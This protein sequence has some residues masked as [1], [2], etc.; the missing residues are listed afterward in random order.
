MHTNEVVR[1]DSRLR[2][3]CL[4]ASPVLG[5]V[6]S[7]VRLRDEFIELLAAAHFYATDRHRYVQNG[8]QLV[9]LFNIDAMSNFL[10]YQQRPVQVSGR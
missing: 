10:R 2:R 8:G 7:P 1:S 9:K 6:E 4:V 5:L 3:D